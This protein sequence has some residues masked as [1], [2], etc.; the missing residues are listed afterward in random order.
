[1][2]IDGK[3]KALVGIFLG[4]GFPG[5]VVGNDNTAAG[6]LV[7]PIDATHNFI[8]PTFTSK[9]LRYEDLRSGGRGEI[10]PENP[11]LQDTLLEIEVVLVAILNARQRRARR[12]RA[13][14]LRRP[15]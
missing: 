14:A 12:E 6:R 10:Q 3:L 13:A 1:M 8:S 5:L 2:S 15:S 4:L 11:Q 9:T 7:D